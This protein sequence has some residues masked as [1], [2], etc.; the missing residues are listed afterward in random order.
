MLFIEILTEAALQGYRCNDKGKDAMGQRCQSFLELTNLPQTSRN[1]RARLGTCA[2][3]G[4]RVCVCHV[5]SQRPCVPTAVFS[6]L[7]IDL[8]SIARSGDASIGEGSWQKSSA[9][10]VK[11]D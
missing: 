11:G 2:C 8:S 1:Y 6:P 3:A 10:F 5:D 7:V 4:E 9:A